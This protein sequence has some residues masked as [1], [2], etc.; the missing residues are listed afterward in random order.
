MKAS[1]LTTLA[2]AP[3]FALVLAGCTPKGDAGQ[4]QTR[5]PGVESSGGGTSGQ[6]MT[7][8]AG[9]KTDATYAGGT[10]GIAGG[11][12]GNTGGAALGGTVSDSGKGPSEGVSNPGAANMP[13]V[14]QQTSGDN[15]PAPGGAG[16]QPP[17]AH[18]EPGNGAAPG[19]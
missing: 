13:G 15:R 2:L 10:P 17:A 5:F 16:P 1:T 4:R 8:N 6:V 3:A 12:G 18:H 9:N 7:A 14:N 11:S 19:R